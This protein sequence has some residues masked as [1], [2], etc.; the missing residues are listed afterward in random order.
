ME[1]RK[2]M[3]IKRA[4]TISG[5]ILCL[6]IA[7]CFVIYQFRIQISEYM[8]IKDPTT[9]NLLKLS[10]E[11]IEAH[12]YERMMKYLPKVIE[13]D[14]LIEISESKKLFISEFQDS[15]LAAKDTFETMLV[16]SA[17]SYIYAEKYPEFHEYFPTVYR[18]IIQNKAYAGWGYAMMEKDR[19]TQAG[20]RNILIALDDISPTLPEITPDNLEKIHEYA[21]NL[22]LKVYVYDNMGDMET[23]DKLYAQYMQLIEELL[24]M[25]N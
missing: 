11:I 16:K 20:Y 6:V 7:V 23:G 5:I 3:F 2:S 17:L 8:Y 15:S 22:L 1:V 19:I 4:L 12:D 9:A 10:I 13:L 25:E 21:G 18:K 24:E 14:D